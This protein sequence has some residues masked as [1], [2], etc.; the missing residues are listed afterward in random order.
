MKALLTALLIIILIPVLVIGVALGAVVYILSAPT[1][2]DYPYMHPAEDISSIEFAEISI[3]G[4]EIDVNGIGFITDREALIEDIN[5]L[6]R[7]SKHMTDIFKNVANMKEL[8]GIVINYN[9]G[10]FEIITAYVN[11]KSA[12]AGTTDFEIDVYLFDMDAFGAM[13]D[14]YKSLY[15][16]IK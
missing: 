7:N 2:L 10:S 16:E 15:V 1:P 6:Q 3:N 14:E 5:N 11:L 8:E 13:L 9:D 12:G 4:G